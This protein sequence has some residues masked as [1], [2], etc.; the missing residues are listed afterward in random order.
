MTVIA[1]VQAAMKNRKQ[2]LG[3]CT[4]DESHLN[5]SLELQMGK[6]LLR[7]NEEEGRQLDPRGWEGGT[8]E[9][10]DGKRSE[11]AQKCVP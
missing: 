7:E 2:S 6:D 10:S 5:E 11:I 1:H 3:F 8:W 4:A 9:S